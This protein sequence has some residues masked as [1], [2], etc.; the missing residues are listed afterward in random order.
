MLK[1]KKEELAR[2]E[3]GSAVMQ[4]YQT[5]VTMKTNEWVGVRGENVEE[6][7]GTKCDGS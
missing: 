4:E 7:Q 6:K 5:A 2:D 3:R 1:Q